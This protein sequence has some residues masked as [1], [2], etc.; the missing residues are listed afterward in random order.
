MF[1]HSNL[2][3][4]FR[5]PVEAPAV[6]VYEAI[7]SD[8]VFGTSSIYLVYFAIRSFRKMKFSRI[9]PETEAMLAGKIITSTGSVGNMDILVRGPVYYF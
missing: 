8:A 6:T 3:E 9:C 7:E 4:V 2:R 5:H 1:N